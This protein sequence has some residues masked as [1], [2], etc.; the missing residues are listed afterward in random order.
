MKT[1]A[2]TFMAAPRVGRHRVEHVPA[3]VAPDVMMGVDDQKLG[4]DHLLDRCP[5]DQSCAAVP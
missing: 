3:A 4:P 2:T 1:V 5:T